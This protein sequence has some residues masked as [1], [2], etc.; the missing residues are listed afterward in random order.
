MTDIIDY[1][2]GGSQY[3]VP[4]NFEGKGKYR[5]KEPMAM[6]DTT[7]SM[8]DTVRYGHLLTRHEMAYKVIKGVVNE[9]TEMDAAG[10]TEEDGGG[11]KVTAFSANRVLDFGDL[12]PA[13]LDQK[14]KQIQWE[15]G[16]LIVPGWKNL[17]GN[18]QREFGKVP[19]D[20]QP[21]QLVTIITDGEA[22]DLQEFT[23]ML[24][25]EEDAYVS[26]VLMGYHHPYY[27]QHNTV[28]AHQVA[29]DSFQGLAAKNQ[30]VRVIDCTDVVDH[31]QIC[32]AILERATQE[33]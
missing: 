9:L 18:Y 30:R 13:N 7:G 22:E 1:E 21:L 12:S 17:Q 26:V 14:W 11:I 5:D 23:K 8:N 27:K 16:T 28:S 24:E 32:A 19:V 6:I 29:L 15:G 3:S 33:K 10:K 2:S 25:K 31:T 20:E 4:F